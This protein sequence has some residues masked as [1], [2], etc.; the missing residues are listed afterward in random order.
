MEVED[1]DL[2]VGIYI[3]FLMLKFSFKDMLNVVEGLV[4]D[5]G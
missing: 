4:C 2:G 5:V 3:E 1:W